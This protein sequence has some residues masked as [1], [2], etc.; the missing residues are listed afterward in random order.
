MD[1]VISVEARPEPPSFEEGVRKKGRAHFRLACS[2]MNTRKRDYEDVL[3]PFEVAN[4]WFRL[5]LVTGR[6]HAAPDLT[7]PLEAQVTS[8]IRRLGLDDAANREM[9]ARSYREYREKAFTPE[10][11]RKMNPFVWEEAKRQGLL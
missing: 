9:R 1:F 11:L 8:T 4:G 3:D 5:E 7:E 10:F 2:M 6:I